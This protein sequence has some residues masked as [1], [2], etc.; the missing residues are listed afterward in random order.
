MQ[1]NQRHVSLL[2]TGNLLLAVASA[3]LILPNKVISGGVN[4]IAI[5]FEVLFDWDTVV[6]INT[7]IFLCFVIGAVVLGKEFALKTMFSSFCYPILLQVVSMIHLP[8]SSQLFASVCGGACTGIGIG[9]IMRAGGSSGG[10][11]VPP[12]ILQKLSGVSVSTWVLLCDGLIV[13]SGLL[14][15]GVYSILLGLVSV[16]VCARC[17]HYTMARKV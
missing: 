10:M 17:L 14:V 16:F 7:T 1:V 13:I 4:G 2:F 9:L 5:V 6:V 15:Y 11:D 3:W 12:L 8:A